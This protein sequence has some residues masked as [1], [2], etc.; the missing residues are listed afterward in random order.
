M[1]FDMDQKMLDNFIISTI[2]SV[3][4]PTNP[5]TKGVLSD[6]DYIRGRSQA[7]IQ[8]E[9]TEIL[10]TTP[11]DIKAFADLLTKLMNADYYSVSGSEEQINKNRELFKKIIGG[12]EK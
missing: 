7:D 8:K 3:D 1:K 6:M 9:R 12:S 4:Y 2:G 5:A 11:E 10:S